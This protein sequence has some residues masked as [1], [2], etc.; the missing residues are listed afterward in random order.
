MMHLATEIANGLIICM[1]CLLACIAAVGAYICFR[2]L[3]I[4]GTWR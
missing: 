4:S 1:L 3:R 2:I